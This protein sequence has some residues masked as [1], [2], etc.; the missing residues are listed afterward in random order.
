MGVSLRRGRK[1]SLVSSVLD[2]QWPRWGGG[3][4]LFRKMEERRGGEAE[5]AGLCVP[6]SSVWMDVNECVCV[7]FPFER[8][9]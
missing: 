8:R 5:A 6:V 1:P 4:L 9:I 3:P 7:C 2:P